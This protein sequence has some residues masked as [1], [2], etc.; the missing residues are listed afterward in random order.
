MLA[1]LAILA[2][3]PIGQAAPATIDLTP[4]RLA[5]GP[6]DTASCAEDPG[7]RYRLPLPVERASPDARTRAVDEDGRECN[8]VGSERCTGKPH[9]IVGT[10]DHA[11][12]SLAAR[13]QA[14]DE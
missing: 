11:D 14:L 8:L 10:G 3:M 6:C 7:S 1:A 2:A 12:R 9:L 13:L 5:A 4:D